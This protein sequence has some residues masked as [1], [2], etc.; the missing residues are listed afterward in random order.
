MVVDTAPSVLAYVYLDVSE[1]QVALVN[2]AMLGVIFLLV[3]AVRPYFSAG[4][5]DE[6]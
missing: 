1:F 6:A 3:T 2:V 5:E 4:E